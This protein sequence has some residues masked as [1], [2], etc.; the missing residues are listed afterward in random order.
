MAKSYRELIVWQRAIAEE[1]GEDVVGDDPKA[2]TWQAF[3]DR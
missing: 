2:V 1:G 3:P